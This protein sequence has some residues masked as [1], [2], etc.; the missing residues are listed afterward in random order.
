M[1]VWHRSIV[2]FKPCGKAEIYLATI[3]V[4]AV[5]WWC[6]LKPCLPHSRF[7]SAFD[8]PRPHLILRSPSGLFN[9]VQCV[10][11]CVQAGIWV[12]S[13]L[14]F[15]GCDKVLD[16]IWKDISQKCYPAILFYSFYCFSQKRENDLK[17]NFVV[18]QLSQ[19]RSLTLCCRYPIHM[20]CWAFYVCW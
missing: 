11:V 4:I 2:F 6:W 17:F 20:K 8:C 15:K 19:S 12:Q 16:F 10:C 18:S 13:V 9:L 3:T 1:A 5:V 14:N 7:L